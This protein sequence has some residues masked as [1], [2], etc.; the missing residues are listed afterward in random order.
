M[1]HLAL[2]AALALALVA[3]GGGAA[4]SFDPNSPPTGPLVALSECDGPPDEP[5]EADVEGIELP[6]DATITSVTPQGPLINLTAYIPVTP[7]NVRLFYENRDD[8]EILIIE[9]EI[10]EAELLVSNGTHRT[11]VKASAICQTG[12]TAVIVVAAELDADG[13]PV[14]AGALGGGQNE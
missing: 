5:V 1:R 3:C 11:Y 7:V 10:F 14:P 9:D 6:P 12:S 2:L 13:L 8:L 4:P